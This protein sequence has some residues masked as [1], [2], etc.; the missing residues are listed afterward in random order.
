METDKILKEMTLEEKAMLV[1][2]RDMWDTFDIERLGL[3]SIM[4]SD[5]PHGLRKMCPREGEKINNG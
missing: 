1:A 2:G 4:M 5:G 3:P